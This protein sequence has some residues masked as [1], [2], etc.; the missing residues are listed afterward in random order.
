MTLVPCSLRAWTTAAALAALIGLLASV[1]ADAAT[2]ATAPLRGATHAPRQKPTRR[3]P[4][5]KR[6]PWAVIQARRNQQRALS[7]YATMQSTY[8]RPVVGRYA[9][10]D[11]W[12]Y[13]QAMA[14]TI[15]V[16]A[17]PDQ[18]HVYRRDLIV[19]LRGLQTYADRVH[20]RP[21]GYV[22][23]ASG[24][25]RFNDD[26]EWIGIELLRLYHLNR[27]AQLLHSAQQLLDMVDAQW[28]TL[29]NVACPGGVPWESITI[30]HDR[31]TVSNATGA[32]LGAQ[33][34]LT[35]RNADD[36]QWAKRMYAWV[37]GCLLN[38]DGLYGDHVSFDNTIDATEWTYNQGTMIGAGVMLYKATGDPTYLQQA[39]VTAQAALAAFGPAQLATQPT[40]FNAIYIRNLLLLGGASGDLRYQRFAQWYAGDAWIN[41]RDLSSGLFL[42]EPGGATQLLDQAA[43]VQVY[44]LLAEPP[45][46]YF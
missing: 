9:G 7:S 44:A 6:V 22:S 42:S 46:A 35:T 12:P 15:S 33:L 1:P 24:G 13:S 31:N 29:P 16:A 20:P 45:S 25:T 38:G 26:N 3:R 11:A 39:E 19:R 43:M 18:Y 4:V 21:A 30:N 2:I 23:Q 37:R 40:Y 14:A 5:P 27:Q 36:L 28:Y 41:V 32:E 17:L 34:Y 10:A 8:Y